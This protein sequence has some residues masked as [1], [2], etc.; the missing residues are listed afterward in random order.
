MRCLLILLIFSLIFLIAA[1]PAVFAFPTINGVSVNPAS[2]LCIGSSCDDVSVKVNCSSDTGNSTQVNGQISS[3]IVSQNLSSNRVDGLFVFDIPSYLF[4]VRPSSYSFT[5]YCDDG[6]GQ[7]ASQTSFYVSNLDVSLSSIT[8]P[9]YIGSNSQIKVSV[10][11]DDS[12]VNSPSSVNFT[13]KLGGQDYATM[14]PF[15]DPSNDLW[16]INFLPPSVGG[17]YTYELE[18]AI[19]LPSSNQKTVTLSG[20]ISVNNPI[21]FGIISLDKAEVIPGDQIKVSIRATELGGN[22]LLSKDYLRFSVGSV[23]IPKENFTIASSGG[24]FDVAFIVPGLSPGFYD[25]ISILDYKNYSLTDSRRI[26]YTT[27]VSGKFQDLGGGAINT[28]IDFMNGDSYVKSLSTD[29]SGAYSVSIVPDNYTLKLSFPQSTLFIYGMNF[30]GLSDPIRYYFLGNDIQ[31]MKSAGLFDFEIAVPFTSYK[32]VMN[33]DEKKVVNEKELVIYRCADFNAPNLVC[34]DGWA[35]QDASIDTNAN[36]VTVSNTQ[37]LTYAIGTK[38][39]LTLESSLEKQTYSPSEPLKVRGIVRDSDGNFVKDALVTVNLNSGS[40]KKT[41]TSDGSGVFSADMTAPGQEGVYQIL[42]TAEK[43]PFLNGNLTLTLQVVKVKS[44]SI[45]APDIIRMYQGESR[46]VHFSIANTGQVDLTGVVLTI[47][48]L[49]ASYYSLQNGFDRIEVGKEVSANVDFNIPEDAGESTSSFKIRVNSNE[50]SGES[51]IGLTIVSK[52]STD[53]SA[54][55][56]EPAS[57]NIPAGQFVLPSVSPDVAYIILFGM[58]SVSLAYAAKRIR[59]RSSVRERD[60]VRNLLTD[61]KGE[62]RRK[63]SQTLQ[64]TSNQGDAQSGEDKNQ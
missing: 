51:V 50:A 33:Y 25:I 3:P 22:I 43:T 8:N 48:G 57:L 31:G 26:G 23:D 15:F 14:P 60:H 54:N 4:A 42:L 7:A 18:V 21:D 47:E 55:G 11:K 40:I 27:I 29:S 20:S 58:V 10:K 9:S 28:R 53:L 37:I 36:T 24:Y 61:I 6:N 41:V 17:S 30:S 44:L 62:I 38:K 5:A 56:T 39:S 32:M 59:V 52:N 2:S 19:S 64:P 13:L 45:V 63:K 34:N 12:V 1:T 35:P 46:S 16:V 49:D